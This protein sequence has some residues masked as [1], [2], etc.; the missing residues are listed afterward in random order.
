[1]LSSCVKLV[2]TAGKQQW[3][4]RG[5]SSTYSP[6]SSILSHD[7]RVKPTFFTNLIPTF[8]LSFSPAKIVALP[9][10]E[11]TFYPV[12]TAPIINRNQINSK[13]RY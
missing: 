11:H 2:E 13:E 4:E 7:G 9:L 3:K 6:L 5:I 8:P 10:V 1:M 12:S